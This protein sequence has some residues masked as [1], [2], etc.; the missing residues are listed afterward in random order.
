MLHLKIASFALVITFS[1]TACVPQ[2]GQEF[3][4]QT[5]EKAR[6][7]GAQSFVEFTLKDA[8]GLLD[9]GKQPFGMLSCLEVRQKVD[10]EVVMLSY[11]KQ[12]TVKQT[13]EN[14]QVT[15]LTDFDYAL[16]YDGKEI[17][18]VRPAALPQL[19]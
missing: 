18:E 14:T 11:I 15:L 16:Y 5:R 7:Y 3:K 12:C 4:A 8:Q 2:P 1:L 6:Q 19:K 17:L 10:P 13:L 9:A